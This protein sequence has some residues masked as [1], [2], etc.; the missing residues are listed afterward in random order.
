MFVD[1]PYKIIYL[2][3]NT[4]HSTQQSLMSFIERTYRRT[5]NLINYEVTGK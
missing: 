5:V 1:S 3:F 4:A 2:F